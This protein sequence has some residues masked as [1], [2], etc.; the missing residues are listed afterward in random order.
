MHTLL[1]ILFS[2]THS[3]NANSSVIAIMRR[4]AQNT[5]AAPEAE[6]VVTGIDLAH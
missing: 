3:T 6:S 1:D 2:V 5:S 4:S